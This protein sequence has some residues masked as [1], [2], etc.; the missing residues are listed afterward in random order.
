MRDLATIATPIAQIA[1]S[2]MAIARMPNSLRL[3]ERFQQAAGV[4]LDRPGFIALKRVAHDGPLRIS[5]LSQRMGLDTSTIS[6]KVHQLEFE[7]LIARAGDPADRRSAVLTIT[8]DGRRVM[9]QLDGQGERMLAQTLSSW[10]EHDIEQLAR[11]LSKLVHDIH[12]SLERPTAAAHSED[13][14]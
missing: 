1:D 8:E 13:A 10:P 9:Q 11:L 14:S 6:R 3:H 7:G 5:D 4:K 12:S 2:M